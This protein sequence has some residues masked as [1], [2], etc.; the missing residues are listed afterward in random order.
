MYYT[1]YPPLLGPDIWTSVFYT[2]KRSLIK[3]FLLTCPGADPFNLK[4]KIKLLGQTDE[5]TPSAVILA[6]YGID[7]ASKG[8]IFAPIY[9]TTNNLYS[10]AFH[11]L[12]IPA[13]GG[14]IFASH[15]QA[16]TE[17]IVQINTVFVKETP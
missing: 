15:D 2:A 17:A 6:L 4:L 1:N 3:S 14:E 9:D 11:D 8:P 12:L 7:D 10:I 13:G 16:Y 5:I